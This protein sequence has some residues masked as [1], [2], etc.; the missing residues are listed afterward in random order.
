MFAISDRAALKGLRE[1]GLRRA[2]REIKKDTEAE[3]M[4]VKIIR[5]VEV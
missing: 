4:A 2:Q 3:I 5:M 1:V